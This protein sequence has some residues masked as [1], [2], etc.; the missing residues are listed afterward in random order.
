M[1]RKYQPFATAPCPA[2][3]KPV[4][5]V[6]CTVQVTAGSTVASG[7]SPPRPAACAILGVWMPTSA[8]ERPTTRITKV[9]FMRGK[10]LLTR[11]KGLAALC[12]TIAFL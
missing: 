11:G 4:S 6:D 10:P 2:G 5:S 7:R 9:G 8:G 3:S 12:K 1:S